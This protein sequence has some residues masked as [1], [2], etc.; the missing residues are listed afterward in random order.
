[1][2]SF[3]KVAKDLQTIALL[4]FIFESSDNFAIAP[5]WWES[6]AS[7]RRDDLFRRFG[8]SIKRRFDNPASNTLLLPKIP[9]VDWNPV[10]AG[11]V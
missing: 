6:L 2:K 10:E 9:W 11:Y 1:V 7:E 4:N 5:Q 8:Y 3:A